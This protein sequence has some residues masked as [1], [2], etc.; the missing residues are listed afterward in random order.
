M[1]QKARRASVNEARQ[2]VLIPCFR[3]LLGVPFLEKG[4]Q[5]QPVE[6]ARADTTG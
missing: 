6:P 3:P 4:M 5:Q 2:G 1:L